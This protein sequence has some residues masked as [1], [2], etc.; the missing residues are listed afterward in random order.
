M[1]GSGVKP[2]IKISSTLLVSIFLLAVCAHL[3]SQPKQQQKTLGEIYRTGSI[4]FKPVL[5][6]SHDTFPENILSKTLI[7]LVQKEDRLYV[8]D[9]RLCD[10]KILNLN[11]QFI[12]SFGSKGKGPTDMLSPYLTCFSKDRLVVWEIGNRR[13]SFFSP[14]GKFLKIE[15]PKIKGR[16]NNMKAFE[17]GRIILEL[18]RVEANKENKQIFEWLVL[19]LY[20]SELKHLKTLYRQ[21]ESRFKYFLKGPYHRLRLPYRL[22]L[23]WDVLIGAKIVVGFSEKYEIKIMDIDTGQTK[24]ISRAYSPVKITEADKKEY[25]E[26]FKDEGKQQK[27]HVNKF[28]RNNVEFPPFKPVFKNIITDNEGHIL[29]FIFSSLDQ[30]KSRY[31]ANTFDVF[32]SSGTFVNNVKIEGNMELNI[33]KVISVSGNAFWFTET[34]ND[35]DVVYVKYEAM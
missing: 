15:K 16:L 18:E 17:D 21:K 27:R 24:S 4:K 12:K 25:L 23:Y 19:E 13:F 22:E 34:E 31:I 6:I 10:V 29:V 11:G 26:Y 32:D 14:G 2:H 5:K 20:S 8:L 9:L 28:I 35:S 30:G 1:K 33:V 7:S 3:A